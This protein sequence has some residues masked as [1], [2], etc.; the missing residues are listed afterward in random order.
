[1]T[2]ACQATTSD[3]VELA[4]ADIGAG[5]VVTLVHGFP[6][7]RSMWDEQVAALAGTY[8]VIAPDLRGFG[9]SGIGPDDARSGVPMERYAADLVAVLDAA[10][11]RAPVVLAGFS[12]GGYVAWQFALQTPE[13][14]RA[15]VLSDTRAAADPPEAAANRRA[16]AERVLAENSPAAAE[17]MIS[18]LLA[19]ATLAAGLPAVA[20]VTAMIRGAS[21]AGIAAAQ[22]GMA[23]R[24][25][26]RDRL[27]EIV[28]P[29]L[30]IVGAED[31]I[32]PPAEMRELA[33]ALPQGRFV[34]V[35]MAGHMAPLENPAAYNAALLDF[36]GRAV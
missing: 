24:P 7:D 31:A 26:V 4:Y 12:M 1:M 10:G 16:M 28:C 30:A 34:E 25:D 6:L 19:P 33:A 9:Q 14:L 3:G 35:P 8:R 23:V 15:L 13:R 27:G 2:A 21:P 22:I 29:A 5:P 11:V 20:R 17:G 36:V 32:S 18:K